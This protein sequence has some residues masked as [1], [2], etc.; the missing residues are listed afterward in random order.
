MSALSFPTMAGGVPPGT[1]T[2]NQMLTSRPGNPASA[3]VGTS[4]NP[5]TRWLEVTASPRTARPALDVGNRGRGSDQKHRDV[6]GDERGDRLRGRTAIGDVGDVDFG[7][8]FEQ[9]R[10]EMGRAADA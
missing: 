3:K 8:G 2:A 6:A 9:L 10:P 4:G 5:C 7:N 1:S